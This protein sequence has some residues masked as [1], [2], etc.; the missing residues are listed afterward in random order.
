MFVVAARYLAR[1]GQ[2]E[3]VAALLRELAAYSNSTAEPGC[4]LYIVNRGIEEPRRF[5]LYE[6][7][8]DR[9]AFDGHTSSEPFQRIVLGQVVPLLEERRR[10]YYDVIAAPGLPGL[11]APP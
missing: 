8:V 11:Q 5:L 1:E 6:Q 10:D 7:Y 4:A 2:D 9:A 3:R